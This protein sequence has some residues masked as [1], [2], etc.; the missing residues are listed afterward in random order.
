MGSFDR[1]QTVSCEL[2][3]QTQAAW[4]RPTPQTKAQLSSRKIFREV[5]R[6]R[7]L[8]TEKLTAVN[9]RILVNCCPPHGQRN[10]QSKWHNNAFAVKEERMSRMMSEPQA[11][12]P[13]AIRR[14]THSVEPSI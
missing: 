13:L 5:P 14:S 2:A 10:D 7:A 8:L 6:F 3:E 11:R 1:N 12:S 4:D 9:F